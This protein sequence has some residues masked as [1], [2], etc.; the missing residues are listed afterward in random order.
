MDYAKLYPIIAFKAHGALGTWWVHKQYGKTR[1]VCK[2]S[3]PY[4]PRT[5]LQQLNRSYFQQAVANWQGFDDSTKNV[6]N[7]AVMKKPLSGYNRYIGLYLKAN[8]NV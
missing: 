8:Y 4:N 7:Q 2:Y 5:E 1:V 6:Y 3:Y